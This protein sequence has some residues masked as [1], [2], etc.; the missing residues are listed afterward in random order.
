VIFR[1]SSVVDINY[2]NL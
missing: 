1:Y 2:I